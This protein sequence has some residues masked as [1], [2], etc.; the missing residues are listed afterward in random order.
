MRSRRV[1][2]AGNQG[3]SFLRERGRMSSED[4]SRTADPL[5]ATTNLFDVAML[6]GVGF[7]IVALTSFGMSDLLTSEDMTIVKNPGESDMEIIVKTGDRVERLSSTGEYAEG[8]GSP[9]G[10][11]YELDDGTVVW[12]PEDGSL[13]PIGGE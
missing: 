8:V 6:I 10:T 13:D 12:V 5:E 3:S 11:V 1:F 9:I 4:H 7:M 2:G